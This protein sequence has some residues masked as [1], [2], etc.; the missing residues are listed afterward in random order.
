MLILNNSY[1]MCPYFCFCQDNNWVVCASTNVL[2]VF[3]LFLNIPPNLSFVL[4][5][6]TIASSGGLSLTFPHGWKPLAFTKSHIIDFSQSLEDFCSCDPS[7]RNFFEPKRELFSLDPTP[8]P[9]IL[10]KWWWPHCSAVSSLRNT[11]LVIIYFESGVQR[12]RTSLDFEAPLIQHRSAV[13]SKWYC[14]PTGPQAK[15]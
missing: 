8:W 7:H 10:I 11:W 3:V 6:H 9:G 12:Y 5:E 14:E 15:S 13:K 2:S 4:W 1:H